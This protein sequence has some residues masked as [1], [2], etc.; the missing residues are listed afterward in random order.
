MKKKTQIFMNK[1]I[2]LVLSKLGISKTVIHE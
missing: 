1:A 2:Y